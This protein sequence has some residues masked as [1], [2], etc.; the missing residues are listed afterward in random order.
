MAAPATNLTA[1]QALIAE[2]EAFAEP[3]LKSGRYATSAEV[4]HAAMEA[5]LRAEITQQAYDRA[6]EEAAEEGERSGIAEGDVM[7]RLRE[8]FELRGPAQR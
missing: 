8:E 1:E 6:C 7:A 2:F 3:F 5:F 4:L